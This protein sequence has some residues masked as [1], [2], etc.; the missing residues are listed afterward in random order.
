MHVNAMNPFLQAALEL[1]EK[2]FNV[3][4]IAPNAKFPAL[5]KYSVEGQATNDPATITAHW[6]QFPNANPAILTTG[7]VVID[8]DTKHDGFASLKSL[9]E[10]GFLF[11]ET[12]TQETPSGG[13]HLVYKCPPEISFNTVS[14]LGKG[15]DTRGFNGYIMAEGAI[16]KDGAYKFRNR[17]TPIAECT[18]QMIEWFLAQKADKAKNL[19]TDKHYPEPRQ[20]VLK[21]AIRYLQVEA[22]I[23]QEGDKGRGKPYVIACEATERFK[24]PRET[25]VSLMVEYY[26][27][28][29]N[30]PWDS[31]NIHDF[32]TSVRNG[33]RNCREFVFEPF[34]TEESSQIE[35]AHDGIVGSVEKINLVNESEQNESASRLFEHSKDSKLHTWEKQLVQGIC[36]P[37]SLLL[38]IGAPNTGKTLFV[39]YMLLS[40]ARGEKWFGRPTQQGATV[41]LGLESSQS[42]IHH[43]FLGYKKHYGLETDVPYYH[44]ARSL[45]LTNYFDKKSDWPLLLKAA[46]QLSDQHGGLAMIAIDTL[47]CGMAGADENDARAMSNFLSGC[48]ALKTL[49]GACVHLVHH[50]GKDEEKGARGSSALL[51]AV[52]TEV[53]V[54][55]NQVISVHKQ[56]RLPKEKTGIAY[57]VVT[58]TIGTDDDGN[59]IT[60]AV[61]APRVE[62]NKSDKPDSDQA[63]DQEIGP[64]LPNADKRPSPRLQFEMCFE[65]LSR[66]GLNRD[67]PMKPRE[68]VRWDDIAERI[69]ETY[70]PGI[71]DAAW[72][73]AKSRSKAAAIE[74]RYAFFKDA[75]AVEWAKLSNT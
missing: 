59:P 7:Y 15:I 4:P 48:N 45:N 9:E 40:I 39:M 46:K 72:R 50:V 60:T 13:I 73:M 56:K 22:N 75:D 18:P 6:T 23:A 62:S 66:E 49:T 47:A 21:D 51:G 12:L 19:P 28:R 14:K 17:N 26:N 37:H 24:L 44:V 8:V 58:V 5:I 74:A 3:I 33:H 54:S 65:Q 29:C 52:D 10:N 64:A 36:M 1:G 2:G 41:Y 27:P 61:A 43:R 57:D 68:S 63:F 38:T 42:D 70:H 71:N 32:E 20:E 67:E 69:R 34:T 30:P 31:F 53:R 11:P 16:T 25:L 35:T 55:K